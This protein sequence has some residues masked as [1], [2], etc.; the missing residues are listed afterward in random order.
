MALICAHTQHLSQHF[1]NWGPPGGPR[2]RYNNTFGGGAA[3]CSAYKG[4]PNRFR[5]A[6]QKQTFA[7]SSVLLVPSGDLFGSRWRFHPS[8]HPGSGGADCTH[9]CWAS[10]VWQPL[11]ERIAYALLIKA[12]PPYEK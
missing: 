9:Y 8:S 12:R 3:A 1:D 4:H 11:W 7:D 2:S 5:S 6:I 10:R